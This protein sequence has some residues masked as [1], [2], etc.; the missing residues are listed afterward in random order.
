MPPSPTTS[1]S[2]ATQ[3]A[4]SFIDILESA[5]IHAVR[6]GTDSLGKDSIASISAAWEEAGSWRF[7][8]VMLWVRR[9]Y[10]NKDHHD[11][12][13]NAID[14][15]FQFLGK[16]FIG[17]FFDHMGGMYEYKARDAAVLIEIAKRSKYVSNGRLQ[18]AIFGLSGSHYYNRN[19]YLEIELLDSQ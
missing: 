8:V 5:F 12:V 2:S 14:F 11:R 13:G 1:K 6:H 18:A 4:N 9:L 10:P 7:L 16:R 15:V 3:N 19:R 17:V